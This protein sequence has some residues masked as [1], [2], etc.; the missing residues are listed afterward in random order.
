MTELLA[1][2]PSFT[3][4]VVA[5]LVAFLRGTLANQPPTV[6]LRLCD[7]L[8][9]GFGAMA[10]IIVIQNHVASYTVGDS[11]AIAFGMGYLGAGKVS[12][13]AVKLA[14]KKLNIGTDDE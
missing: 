12:E 4:A 14:K 1:A 9:C 13:L 11:I 7:A 10:V 2:V 5:M 3:A 6:A 8:I